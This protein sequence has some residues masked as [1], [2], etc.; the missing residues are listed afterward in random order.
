MIEEPI[1]F[2]GTLHYFMESLEQVDPFN[3]NCIRFYENRGEGGNGSL[4]TQ[5]MRAMTGSL[6]PLDDFLLLFPDEIWLH[7]MREGEFFIADVMT[8]RNSDC[9]QAFFGE[10]EIRC[11]PLMRVPSSWTQ[12]IE[13]CEQV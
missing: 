11:L 3:N 13:W 7:R 10:P 4:S 6:K 5:F 1:E 9:F 8:R 2:E 12:D